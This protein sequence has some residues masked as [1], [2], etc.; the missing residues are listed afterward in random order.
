MGV[1]AWLAMAIVLVATGLLVCTRVGADL[2]LV[3]A[4]TG[5]LVTGVLTP[6]EALS[7]LANEGLAVVGTLYV[8]AVGLVDTGAVYALG[9]R[10]L[11]RPRSTLEAQSR[12]IV[13]VI[14][15][16]AFVNNTPIVAMLVP[17]V[18]DWARKHH[19]SVSKL[20]IP[21]SYAAILG[22][23]CT[24]IGTTTNLIVAGMVAA[25][26]K[27]APIGMFE[28]AWIGVPCAIMGTAYILLVSPWL[29]PER[30]PALAAS[31]DPR[32]Y[33][34]EM[35]VEESGPLVGR[36]IEQAG[37]RH[38]A[39][40]FLAEIERAGE[41]LPAVGPTERLHGEDRLIFV[42]GVDSVVDLYK[43]KGLRPATD[44]VFK[45][46]TPRPDRALVEAVVSPSSPMVRHTIREGRFRSRYDAVV[47][48]V[49]RGGRRI[50]GRIGDIELHAGD[51][52][53][54]EARPNFVE[55]RRNSRDFLLVSAVAGASPP[56][57]DRAWV[58]V[59]I[60][61]AM[62]GAVT[63]VG[64]SMLKAA[65]VAAGL[66][67]ICRCT[68][69][70][71]ARRSVDWQ[72][73]TVIAA[74]LALGKAMQVTG[75]ATAIASGW[76]GLAGTNPT[77]ALAGVFVMTAVLTAIITNNG[78]AVLMF[79]LASAAAA[80]L[81]VDFRPFVI[82]IMMA[83]SASFATPIG[84]QTNLMVYGPGGYLF[85]D[86]IRLGTPLTVLVG[87]VTVG[88]APVVWPF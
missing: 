46:N 8:V 79:P 32:E 22:G 35:L 21:L 28:I 25:E 38:L 18:Q 74:S 1:E 61:A 24:I 20:M 82:T 14:A 52:L 69:G 16:S 34:L 12:L 6:A 55:R 70:R 2:V 76:V 80:S 86:Y 30:K 37:L 81:G 85:R 39:G 4:M 88:V 3:A 51:T 29:L 73:L 62:V 53:L 11:G 31:A 67:L 40:V 7:G 48:A 43:I 56:R 65:M 41:V 66:M 23:T 10:L 87:V 45:L 36:T 75:A 9:Q 44:Q 63:I 49:A 77:L 68:T 27:L 17:V 59:A 15:I 72:V 47:V 26:T 58:A 83:A 33:A 42:G 60:L 5:L 57:H 71:D 54:I 78:A 50:T 19:L 84:Y 13:P 64:V